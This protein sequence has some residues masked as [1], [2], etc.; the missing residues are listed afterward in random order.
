MPDWIGGCRFKIEEVNNGWI[1]EFH[2]RKDG[3][4]DVPKT[5]KHIAQHNQGHFLLLDVLKTLLEEQDQLVEADEPT[6]SQ[7]EV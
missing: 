6:A 1:I 2:P 4:I 3:A 5:Q 7:P